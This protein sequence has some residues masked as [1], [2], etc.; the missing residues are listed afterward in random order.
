MFILFYGLAVSIQSVALNTLWPNYF[1]RKYLGSIRGAATVFMVLGSALGPLPFGVVFDQT[2][3]FV[4]VI[5]GMMVMTIGA[6]GL[7]L[8]IK[9]PTKKDNPD[10]STTIR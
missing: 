5:L 6:I 4:P 2:Q 1:G 10:A 9:K 8:F 7:T 3:S